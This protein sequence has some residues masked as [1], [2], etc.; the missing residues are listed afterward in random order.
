M[1]QP[2][3]ET[4]WTP[5]FVIVTP[6]SEAG[7]DWLDENTDLGAYGACEHRYIGEL[8]EGAVADGL[9]VMDTGTGRYAK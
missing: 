7:L 8:V 5:S 1:S 9:L 2:D 3:I 4:T 6:V